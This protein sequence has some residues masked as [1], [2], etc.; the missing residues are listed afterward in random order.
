MHMHKHKHLPS[1][2]E[3]EPSGHVAAGTYTGPA[4]TRGYERA[5]RGGALPDRLP[6]AAGV[7][8]PIA[9][10]E[11]VPSRPP[12]ARRGR[13]VADRRHY[14]RGWAG[15]PPPAPP[16]RAER[17]GIEQARYHPL[18]QTVPRM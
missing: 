6:R 2:M 16:S 3:V 9:L 10:L 13:A 17:R 7:V 8:E 5:R 11:L 4:G 12:G 18:P 14:P 1:G 15:T